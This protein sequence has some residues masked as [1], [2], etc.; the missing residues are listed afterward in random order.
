MRSGDPITLVRRPAHDVTVSM[1]YR[2][3]MTEPHL[4]PHVLLAADELS[5]ELAAEFAA[6]TRPERVSAASPLHQR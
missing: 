3:M 2:A 5:D 6:G 4:M 1:A